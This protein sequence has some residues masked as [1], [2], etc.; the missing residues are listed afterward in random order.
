VRQ[1]TIEFMCASVEERY[2][3]AVMQTW[4]GLFIDYVDYKHSSIFFPRTID[5]LRTVTRRDDIEKLLTGV[6]E[7]YQWANRQAGDNVHLE[8][9]MNCA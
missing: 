3:T 9:C 5:Q 7:L 8:R 6:V 2:G 4:S 1:K